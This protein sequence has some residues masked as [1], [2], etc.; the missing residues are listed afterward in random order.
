MSG[1]I[2]I[3]FE[4]RGVMH[5]HGL[6]AAAALTINVA[7]VAVMLYALYRTHKLHHKLP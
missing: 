3:P 7:I 4:I 6:T 1:A 2:Y 5:G